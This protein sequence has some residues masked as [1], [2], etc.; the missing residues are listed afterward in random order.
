MLEFDPVQHVYRVAGGVVPGVTTV[1]RGALGDP[2][3]RVAAP[4]LERARQRGNA[5]HKACE[6]DD[7]GMLDESS[8]D[9]KIAAYVDAWRA[10]RREFAFRVLFAERPLYSALYGYAGTPDV[11]GVFEDSSVI[12][13]DRKTGLPGPAAALQTAAY[14]ALVA[15]ATPCAVPARFALRMLPSGKYRMD[16]YSGVADWRD[17]LSCLNV[18]RLR[19]RLAA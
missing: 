19:E 12:V 11:V 7:A 1:I 14:A 15:E 10:F 16:E 2:F 17:F 18:H 6:L 5:V 4:I 9:P 3:E 8:V 13:I